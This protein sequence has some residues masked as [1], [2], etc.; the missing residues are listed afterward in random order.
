MAEMERLPDA[1][2]P[3]VGVVPVKSPFENVE[4]LPKDQPVVDPSS[5]SPLPVLTPL[6]V[7][8]AAK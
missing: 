5:I 8:M 1:P 2:E 3:N 6:D 7:V 4:L